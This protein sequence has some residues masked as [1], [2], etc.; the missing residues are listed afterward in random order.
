[1]RC[2]GRGDGVLSVRVE[3]AMNLIDSRGL[4]FAPRS[5]WCAALISYGVARVG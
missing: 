2:V 1:M 5:C 3:G 4:L